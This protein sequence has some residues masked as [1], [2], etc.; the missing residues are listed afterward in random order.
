MYIKGNEIRKRIFAVLLTASLVALS[1]CGNNAGEAAGGTESTVAGVAEEATDVTAMENAGTLDDE[2]GKATEEADETKADADAEAADGDSA[3]TIE[4]V[5]SGDEIT[6]GASL[7][8][9]E[10]LKLNT[11]YHGKYTEGE[12][13]VSFK[14]GDEEDASYA[15]M[16]DNLSVDSD[17]I[18]AFLYDEA[19]AHV[20]PDTRNYYANKLARASDEFL[21]VRAD[22]SG[23]TAT[24]VFETLEPDTSYYLR[25]QGEN[26]ADFILNIHCSTE[27]ITYFGKSASE[28]RGLGED[29]T[30]V[31][32]TSQSY[33]INVPLETKVFGT[34]Q[35]GYAW[36]SFTTT[37]AENVG[38]AVSVVN[39]TVDSENVSAFLHDV[40]GNHVIPDRRNYYA[41]RLANA[42]D[43]FLA[44]RADNTGTA[45][46]GYFDHLKPD[47]TY[48]LCIRGK[49]TADYSVIVSA[50]EQE[51]AEAGI[52]TNQTDAGAGAGVD[53]E[54]FTTSTVLAEAITP[55]D[56]DD[57]FYTGTNQNN[58][59]MLKLNTYYQGDYND[60]YSWVTFRTLAQEGVTYYVSLQNLTPGSEKLS[61]FL[62]DVYGNHVIPDIRNYYAEKLANASDEFL[63]ARA[64]ES[65]E[66]A[67]GTFGTL[68]PNT[69]YYLRIQGG[70]AAEYI[71][72]LGCILAEE[73][74]NTIEETV[75]EETV[76]EEA[77][78][79]VPFELND[80]QVMFKAESSEF[81]YP[82]AV[83]EALQPIAEIILAHP[84]HQILLA[85]T[86]ATD[87]TQEHRVILSESRAAAVKKVLV[88]TFGVP[89]EQLLTIGLG[90]AADPFER[91]RDRDPV[92]DPS[93]R[94]IETEGAKNRRVV[95]LDA[96]SEIAKMVLDE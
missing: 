8:E 37:E 67:M 76:I 20:I 21:A 64:D 89:E 84:D 15:L 14:T 29:T 38:Y 90:Y 77:V 54:A 31:P 92:G 82:D 58:P 40:Y 25:I 42:S 41:E 46:T 80:T 86:T 88:E 49:D 95:V 1:A 47:T 91:G 32:G 66:T 93:G 3:E 26:E 27:E 36:V 4:K 68:A 62:Y 59:T 22:N 63:A 52:G 45:A 5:S 96:E 57:V 34:Y 44:S 2:M 74:Q 16:L 9:A 7:K 13:W 69:T 39:C 12:I 60:G 24:G 17:K 65:G 78:F 33:S 85:G 30:L 81:V 28:E 56:E 73:E 55:L 11:W 43:E 70:S 48:F 6:G 51:D 18:S 72:Y 35:N 23:T 71:L 94:F 61:S 83:K 50:I 79:E 75:I 19:G 53:E 10:Q 87:G